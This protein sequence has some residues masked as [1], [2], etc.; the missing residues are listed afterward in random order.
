MSETLHERIGG[1]EVVASIAS[2]LVDLHLENPK[3]QTRFQS[4]DLDIPKLKG[5]VRDHLGS[6]TGGAEVYT[7]RN[8]LEAHKGMNLSEEEYMAALDDA[9]IALNKN[10]VGQREQEEVL[11]I[12]YSFRDEILRK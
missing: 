11:F 8:M 4:A 5:F 2:D 7:G 10:S 1:A 6:G 9:L 12:L 3:I